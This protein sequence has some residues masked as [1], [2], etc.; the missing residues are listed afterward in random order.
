MAHTVLPSPQRRGFP[1]QGPRQRRSRRRRTR[2]RTLRVLAAVVLVGL[3]LSTASY[4][5]A[6]TYPGQAMW[7]QRSI[8]WLRAHGGSLIVNRTENWYYTRHAPATSP[9]NPAS[10]PT[11][12]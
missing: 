11:T 10:L 3:C 7:Q 6:L 12:I 2:R 9:P 4:V 8:S 5:R 1:P